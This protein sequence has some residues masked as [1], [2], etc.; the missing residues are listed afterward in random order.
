MLSPPKSRTNRPL[1]ALKSLGIIART[2]S[3]SPPPSASPMPERSLDEMSE[4]EMRAELRQL[5]VSRRYTLHYLVG[6]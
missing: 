5:R 3:P 6:C 4:E 1:A 2:P